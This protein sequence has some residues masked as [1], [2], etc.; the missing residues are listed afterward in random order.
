MRPLSE[1]DA[2][3]VDGVVFDV[4]DTLTRGGVLE[5]EAFDALWDLRERGLRA[6]AVTGRP[7]GWSDVLAATWPVDLAVGENGA[8]WATRRGAAVEIGYFD[9][10]DARRAQRAVLENVERAVAEELPHVRL[11]D[12]CGARRCD[13]AFDVGERA[14]LD[15]PEIAA[16]VE[17]IERFGARATVSS[18]HAHAVPGGWDKAVGVARAAHAVLGIDG[19]ALRERFVFVGDSGNDA[20]A[21]AFFPR[22]VGVSNV[23]EHLHRL[24]VQPAFVAPGDRGLGFAA[25]VRHL[26]QG[27]D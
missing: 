7:L 15:T 4:D 14:R 21:F 12:D 16:L 23:R 24:P 26:V 11:S 9:T 5:R 25:V 2:A 8:G 27:K 10:A 1:L 17:V 3:G 19:V 20:A 6:I 22:T 13:V 18:V